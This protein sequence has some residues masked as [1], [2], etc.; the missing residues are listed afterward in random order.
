MATAGERELTGKGRQRA[1]FRNYVILNHGFA[2]GILEDRPSAFHK[3]I[4]AKPQALGA[5][6]IVIAQLQLRPRS[7]GIG[8]HRH[9][10]RALE[11]DQ[12]VAARRLES[13]PAPVPM[14]GAVHKCAVP[15]HH[16]IQRVGVEANVDVFRIAHPD[17]AR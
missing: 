4:A 9:R 5:V 1:G 3:A 2:R 13:L 10:L 14:L 11:V 8:Q 17:T 16:N 6:I 12:V 15:G 7:L